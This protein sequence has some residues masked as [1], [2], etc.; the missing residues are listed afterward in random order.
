MVHPASNGVSTFKSILRGVLIRLKYMETYLSLFK[1]TYLNLFTETY[2]TG[3]R[4]NGSDENLENLPRLLTD[5][6]EAGVA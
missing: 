5:H 2:W 6:T 3:D 1:E 4:D